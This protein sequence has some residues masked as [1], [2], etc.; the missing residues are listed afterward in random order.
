VDVWRVGRGSGGSGFVQQFFFS[1]LFNYICGG[2]QGLTVTAFLRGLGKSC[3]GLGRIVQTAG[4][5]SGWSEASLGFS[6]VAT[7]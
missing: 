7:V 2:V 6:F 3:G 5:E 4:L 1:Q